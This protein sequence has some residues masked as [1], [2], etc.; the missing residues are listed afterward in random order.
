M[1]S[2]AHAGPLS[3]GPAVLAGRFTTRRLP[4]SIWLALWAAVAAAET[5]A[6]LPLLDGAYTK[7]PAV[8]VV[9]R[10][11]GGSFAV[12]GLIAWRRRP[13]NRTGPLMTATGFG[14]FVTPLLTQIDSP[15]AL[16]VAYWLPDI[17]LLFFLMILL[18]SLTG[19]RLRTRLDRLI[20]AVTAVVLL[21]PLRLLFHDIEG[22]L[23]LVDPNPRLAEAMGTAQRLVVVGVILVTVAVIAAR[24]R[25]AS[26]ARRRALLPSV[27]GAACLVLWLPVLVRD[28]LRGYRFVLAGQAIDWVVAITVAIVPL[29]FLAGL[30]RSRLARGELADLFRTLREMRPAQLQTALGHA[31]GDPSLVIAYRR[32]GRGLENADG[33]TVALPTPDDDRSAV[34]VER[35]GRQVAAL[36]YDTSLD[37]D[38][39]LVEAA[40]AAAATALENW[41]LHAEVQAHLAELRE[42]RERI[43]AAGDA[44][45]RRIER[46]LHDGAQ[47]RLVLL[48][49]QMS[50]IQ[51]Q[52]RADPA[53]AEQL[54]TSAG[55][56][57]A[58]SL[59]ELRE[60]ARGLHPAALDHGLDVA[61]EALT[62]SSAV[63]TTVEMEPGPRM[64]E[65][66]ALAAYFV[67][68]EALTNVAKYA[69]ATCAT[70]RVTRPQGQVVVEVT[71]DGVGGADPTRGTG[72]RGLRDR[73]EAL[74]GSLR[75]DDA[76]TGGTVVTAHL[77]LSP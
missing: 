42:S 32:P 70:V 30:L 72:L 73:V 27:A 46:N 12:C 68:S 43:I 17:W 74:G 50:T 48:A 53:S 23:F 58:R 11:V 29:V 36:V 66:V 4:T 75:V 47:Q 64:P 28:F 24:F 22:N 18:T 52:I 71:D 37:D 33:E 69:R 61:L 77:P 2:V 19:G 10:L 34:W 55:N 44:E 39:E 26:P 54:V 65:P 25:A 62:V 20:V 3:R 67:T 40:Q 35:D 14:F 57:L 45:R 9:M 56:E 1:T 38:P 6:L 51:R 8:Y 21:V 13:D 15:V 5:A 41:E 76:P 49:M 16:T 7:I 60:L 31:I 59:A 63:P